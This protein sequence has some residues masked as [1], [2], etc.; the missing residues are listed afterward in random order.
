MVLD[1]LQLELDDLGPGRAVNFGEDGPRAFILAAEYED[2]R[3]FGKPVE[4]G[5]L[6]ERGDDAEAN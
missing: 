6:D 3:G 2:T 4:Q 1:D 5:E